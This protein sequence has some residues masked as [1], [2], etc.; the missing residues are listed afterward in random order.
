MATY[1]MRDKIWNVALS[2]DSV[3]PTDLTNGLEISE[4]TARDTLETMHDMGWLK[5]EGGE[6]SE[7]T[8]YSAVI[9]P[10]PKEEY[11]SIR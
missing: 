6:G 11:A 2:K 10:E 8:R 7:P 9:D 3:H 4:R 1:T 5:K